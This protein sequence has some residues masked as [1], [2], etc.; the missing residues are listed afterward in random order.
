M[1]RGIQAY[2][3]DANGYCDIAYHFIVDRFGGIWEAPR[4]RHRPR[5]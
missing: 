5:R 1:I 3:M 2:H 4:R